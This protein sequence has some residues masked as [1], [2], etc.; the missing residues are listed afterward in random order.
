MR[1]VEADVGHAWPVSPSAAT[2]GI[3]G[4]GRGGGRGSSIRDST[5]T[6]PSTDRGIGGRKA[7]RAAV[8]VWVR[9]PMKFTEKSAPRAAS[10]SAPSARTVPCAPTSKPMTPAPWNGR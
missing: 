5:G 6:V 4:G 3:D 7:W 10:A 8:S 9:T 2:T 1:L